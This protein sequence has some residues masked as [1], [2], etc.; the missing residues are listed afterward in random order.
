MKVKLYQIDLDRDTEGRAFMSQDWLARKAENPTVIDSTIYD[1]VFDGEIDGDSLEDAFATFNFDHPDG[2]RGRS[3]S[4]S[5]VLVTEFEDGKFAAHFCDSIGFTDV[6]HSSIL[7]WRI[8]R[9]EEP[10]GLLSIRSQ[11]VGHH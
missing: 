7:A 11:R 6:D 9:T 2:F 1:C 3:M 4:V 5:D 8:P 10:G